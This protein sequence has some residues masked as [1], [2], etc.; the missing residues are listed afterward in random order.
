MGFLKKGK[1]KCAV[2]AR[3]CEVAVGEGGMQGWTH[4]VLV[5]VNC[6]GKA[7]GYSVR[8]PSEH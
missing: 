4:A 8:A 7:L 1:F 6:E 5:A 2:T 3:G